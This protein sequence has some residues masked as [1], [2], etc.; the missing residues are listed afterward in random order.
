MRHCLFCGAVDAVLM[1]TKVYIS[2]PRIVA[3]EASEVCMWRSNGYVHGL[4]DD[5]DDDRRKDLKCDSKE[6]W[7]CTCLMYDTIC[8]DDG[9][10]CANE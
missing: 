5:D 9:V 6:L 10:L 2:M 8:I 4:D 7:W 1:Y 3:F